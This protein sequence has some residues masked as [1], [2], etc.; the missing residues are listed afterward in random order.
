MTRQERLTALA[1]FCR[2]FNRLLEDVPAEDQ[3]EVREL[4]C[5]AMGKYL[6]ITE[7][8]TDVKT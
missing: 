5:T 6:K 2:D 4:F 3:G 7:E 1:A 8:V